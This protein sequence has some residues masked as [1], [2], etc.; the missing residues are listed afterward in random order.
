MP[1]I[2]VV[3]TSFNREKYIGAAIQ[4]VLCSTF[5]DF[6]LLVL[7]DAS[8]D[9]TLDVARS[10]AQRDARLRVVANESNLGDYR[11]RNRAIDLVTTPFLKYHDSD[12]LIYPHCLGMMLQ[13]LE[14]ELSAG[15]AMSSG[16]AW[17][18]G[19]CPMFLSPRMAYL[20]EYLGPGMFSGGPSVALFRTEVLRGLGGFPERGVASDY[21]FWLKACAVTSVVLVPGDLFWY[22][23]H[24]GQEFQSE[25]AARDYAIGQGESWRALHAPECPLDGSTLDLAKRNCA[26]LLMKL[27]W[28]DLKAGRFGLARLRLQSAGLRPTDLVRYPPRRARDLLAGTPLTQDGEYLVPQWLQHPNDRLADT[29]VDPVGTKPQR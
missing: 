20:R 3:I 18:G 9:G 4:S 14:G 19:P 24:K 11:N 5:S 29:A 10:Y 27:T 28:R 7:D 21:C 25:R 12:D 26:Y 17:L 22:R 8:T 15:F 1:P 6:Q 23:I 13:L 16:R 2:T